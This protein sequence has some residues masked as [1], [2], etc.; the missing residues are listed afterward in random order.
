MTDF[1]KI[2][3]AANDNE[4]AEL[5]LYGYIGEWDDVS[6]KEVVDELKKITSSVINVKINSYGGAVFTAQAIFSSLVRHSATINV[7]IDGIAASAATIIAMAGDKIVIPSNAMM[8]IHNP[9]TFAMGDSEE[10]RGVADAMDKVR[11]SII[12]AYERKASIPREQIIQ[13]MDEE[14]WM[15]AEEAV[16]YGFA[17]EVEASQKIAASLKNGVVSINNVSF[18]KS[19]FK[20]MPENFL[21][22]EKEL[23]HAPENEINEVEVV[24][25]DGLKNKYPELYNSILNQGRDEGIN[26]ERER[27]RSIEDTAVPGHNELLA[28]AKFDEPVSADEFARQILNAEKKSR[29]S[30]INNR[31]D[32]ASELNE[33]LSTENPTDKTERLKNEKQVI[34]NAMTKGYLKRRGV[35]NV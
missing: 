35:K 1:W 28:K 4:P 34:T 3:A 7:F 8:M 11:D 16:S 13:L 30:F 31:N 9:W 2:K 18:D 14:T 25:L 23:I 24:D 10:L 26:S 12:A 33:N 32:D 27:I 19:R 6:S 29:Q 21:E 20:N 17:D 22:E 15:S 5:Q